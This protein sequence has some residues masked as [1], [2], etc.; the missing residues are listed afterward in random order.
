[1]RIKH[2]T[3]NWN[4]PEGLCQCGCGRPTNIAKVTQSS[5]GWIGGKHK[6]FV[7]GHKGPSLPERF[8]VKV[9]MSAKGG[10]WLWQAK[11]NIGG[12]GV[13][14]DTLNTLGLG[15]HPAAH[16]VAYVLAYGPIPDGLHVCHTCDVRSCVNPHHLWLGTPADNM[17]DMQ[18]KG[19]E[20]DMKGESHPSAKLSDEDV[21]FIRRMY[22]PHHPAY[23]GKALAQRFGVSRSTIS[24]VVSRKY[25]NHLQPTNEGSRES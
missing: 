8:W 12:Y 10:C 17:R 5:R 6:P 20:A 3:F 22:Q 2:T 21:R 9:D 19:R 11:I 23:S 7:A 1:M 16:R 15:Q 14:R 18:E 4:I 25:W 13:F 24:T